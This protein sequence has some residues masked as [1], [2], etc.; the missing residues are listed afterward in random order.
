L[1][2]RRVSEEL[3]QHLGRSPTRAEVAEAL[4]VDEEVMERVQASSLAIASTDAAL[5][6]TDDLM[7]GDV[8]PDESVVDPAQSVDRDD[9]RVVLEDALESLD[10]RER[11]ILRSRFSRD[12][13]DIPTLEQIGRRL[14][15][16][17]ERVRQL[18]HRALARLRERDDVRRLRAEREAE[19][20]AV[21]SSAP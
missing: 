10:P 5:A 2:S 17:R 13:D 16:S 11:D 19:F 12:G 21:V 9:L 7:L 8:I 18:E 14:G 20:T 6:G 4:E 15:I 3:R 1:R